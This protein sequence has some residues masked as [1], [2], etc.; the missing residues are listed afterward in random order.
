MKNGWFDSSGTAEDRERDRHYSNEA[1]FPTHRHRKTIGGVLMVSME[2]L[3]KMR[4]STLD[5]EGV[6]AL[7]DISEVTIHGETALE[8]LESLLQ[9][10][11]NPYH[12]KVGKTPV[13]ITFTQGAAP[14]E[15]KIKAHFI[16]IKQK[17]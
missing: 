14:L 5:N 6:D 3:E 12:F 1:F 9:Q 11:N 16:S 10:V 7:T 15:E 2:Q 4:L 13:R 8:R 17:T